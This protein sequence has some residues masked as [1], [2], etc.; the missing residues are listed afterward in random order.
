MEDS[1]KH[2]Q[3][4]IPIEREKIFHICVINVG[5]FAQ[6]VQQIYRIIEDIHNF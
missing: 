6:N 2:Y 1:K 3:M 5:D 4:E